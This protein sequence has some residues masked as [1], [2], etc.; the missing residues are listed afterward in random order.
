MFKRSYSIRSE[1]RTKAAHQKEVINKLS[2]LISDFSTG[3]S[4]VSSNRT[5]FSSNLESDLPYDKC[6][7]IGD[8]TNS[9]NCIS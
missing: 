1:K 6:N 4:S 3:E 8:F 7:N 2:N 9:A 5:M